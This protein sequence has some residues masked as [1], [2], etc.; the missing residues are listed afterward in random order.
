[1]ERTTDARLSRLARRIQDWRRTRTKLSP[2]PEQLWKEAASLAQQH[3]VSF[4]AT[5]L[6]LGYAT[7][8]KRAQRSS[9]RPSPEGFVE[10]AGS[11]LIG[12]A[13]PPAP[14]TVLEVRSPDGA[15][16]TLRLPTGTTLDVAALV[17][18]FRAGRP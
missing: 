16:L 10:L 5:A 3:G 11:Q 15:L 1:M 2:M 8:Q 18:S 13:P 12:L 14:E 9:A 6:G 7:L 4:V 17:H